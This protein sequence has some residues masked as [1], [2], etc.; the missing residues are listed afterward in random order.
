[1]ILVTNEQDLGPK[2]FLQAVLSFQNGKII[3]GGNHTPVENNEI[4]VRWGKN[5][6][7]RLN[8]AKGE[9]ADAAEAGEPER[10]KANSEIKRHF[11]KS[12]DFITPAPLSW[13][14]ILFTFSANLSLTL[15][16]RHQ[17]SAD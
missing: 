15:T 6:L 13:E 4:V 3:A 1:M 12:M 8:R 16:N 5:N 10:K 9:R 2:I 7:L 14:A 11:G 17:Q